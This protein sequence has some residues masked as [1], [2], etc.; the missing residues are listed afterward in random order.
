MANKWFKQLTAYEDAV[1]YQYDSFAPENCLYTPSPYWNWIFANKSNGIPRNATILEYSEPKA[2]KSLGIYAMVDEMHHRDKEGIA[3]IFNT[4]HR[5]QLQHEVF[6]TI[7]RERMVIYDTNDPVEIFDRIEKEIKPMVQDGM[8]LRILA[9]DSLTNIMGVKR[10]DADSV[11]QHLMGDR[12]LTIQIGLSKLIPFC[13]RN[14]ILHIAT[15]QIRANMDGGYG[16]PKEKAAASWNTKHTYE[17]AISFKR[18]G[19]ADDKVDIEGKTFEEE[20]LKDARGNKLVLGHKV[21]VKMEGNSI[22]QAGRSGVF[23]LDYK[24]GIINQ[25]EEIFWLGKNTGIIQMEGNKT[26][27]IGKERFNGKKECALA[28]RDNPKLGEAVLAGVKALDARKEE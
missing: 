18:A 25:H 24:N 5:G 14:K 22:G 17:Y 7:D 10:G 3:I 26:Y 6:P 21:Y 1:N 9:I 2:G 23:T 12:A 28:I 13:K 4:E 27:I 11:A 16:Q 15:E 19:A 8:P 20:E